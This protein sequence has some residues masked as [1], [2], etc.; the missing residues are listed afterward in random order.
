MQKFLV[1]LFMIMLF[2]IAPVSAAEASPILKTANLNISYGDRV[3]VTEEIT[4]ANAEAI[5]KAALEHV[6][7]KISGVQLENLDVNAN[8]QKL[9]YEASEG[10]SVDKF[11]VSLPEG[12]QG[13]F[14]YTLSYEVSDLETEKIPFLVPAV[15]SDGNGNV[16]SLQVELPEGTYL[17]ES[18]PI[19]DSGDSGT[20]EEHMMNIP[21]FAGLQT[22]S[23]PAG[24]FTISNF[25]TIF[26]LAVILGIIIA[27]IISER[28]SKA[29]EIV[30]V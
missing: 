27:W 5:P 11:I 12:V 26:G 7:T 13:D 4:I 28:K 24:F 18:F 9:T 21:S 1:L 10:G 20:V 19:I 25:Y 16:V 15:N 17:H 2:S 14:T 3:M 29:G 22:G 30:N 8:N 6:A 23:S